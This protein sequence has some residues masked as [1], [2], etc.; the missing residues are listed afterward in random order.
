MDATPLNH[1]NVYSLRE[2]K[3]HDIAADRL[4]CTQPAFTKSVMVSVVVSMLGCM[5]LIFVEPR[6]KIDSA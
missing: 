1:Q 6:V 5:K 3:K 2:T 4:L